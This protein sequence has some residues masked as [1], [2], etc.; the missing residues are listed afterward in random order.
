MR[1]W[2]NNLLVVVFI[3]SGVVTL[4]YAQEAVKV[5]NVS[6]DKADLVLTTTRT[7]KMSLAEVK[8]MMSFAISQMAESQKA[9][10]GQINYYNTL[11]IEME[12]AGVRE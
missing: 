11:I 3:L 2:F 6:G 8:Q 10:Q 1:N 12:K 9:F 5:E 7:Q 4:S